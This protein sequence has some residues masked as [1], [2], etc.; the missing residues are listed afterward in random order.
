MGAL[1]VQPGEPAR[2]TLS[3]RLHATDV[4]RMP[5]LGSRRVDPQGSSLVDGWISGL[6]RDCG[7][8]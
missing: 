8:D 5:P 3:L 7:E 6:P 1:V 4:W 2:S